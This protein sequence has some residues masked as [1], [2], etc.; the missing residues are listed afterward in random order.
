MA[1]FGRSYAIGC[2]R[3][4]SLPCWFRVRSG[5][6]STS[7]GVTC[8]FGVTVTAHSI[9]SG[10]SRSGMDETVSKTRAR[11]YVCV[12]ASVRV[13]LCVFVFVCGCMC[14]VG[15][16][17][18]G[19]GGGGYLLVLTSSASM[20]Y[21]C[22]LR[23]DDLCLGMDMSVRKCCLRCIRSIINSSECSSRSRVETKWH[24]YTSISR[25]PAFSMLTV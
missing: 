6:C 5:P 25:H 19:W 15:G 23:L 8:V 18:G 16:W 11:V 14:G 13:C 20:C 3:P 4:L 22:M 2:A 17:C 21:T 24:S 12:R 7:L 9:K 1:E 10:L